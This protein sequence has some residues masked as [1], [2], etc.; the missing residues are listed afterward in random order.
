MQF[1]SVLLRGQFDAGNE[2]NACGRARLR[3]RRAAFHRVMVG[4]RN[5]RQSAASGVCGQLLRPIGSVREM[6]V[7]MEVSKPHADC[8]RAARESFDAKGK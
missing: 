1:V 4:Q 7:Q 8:C 5:R 3:R 2:L 6:A